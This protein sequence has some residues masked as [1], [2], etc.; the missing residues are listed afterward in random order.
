[1]IAK[2]KKLN[3]K[4]I[5]EDKLVTSYYQAVQFYEKNQT[6]ILIGAA[7]VVAI[8]LAV[9]WYSN[10][11]MQ[12]N[13]MAN[14]QLS[15]VLPAYNAGNYQLAIDGQDGTPNSGLKKIVEEYGSTDQGE[16]AKLYLANSYYFLG[17]YEEALNYYDSFS[18][19]S[20]DFKAAAAA[21]IAACELANGNKEDA[22]DDYIGA[23]N[24][25]S[26][27]PNNAEYLLNAGK[28]YLELGDTK[29]AKKIFDEI[30]DKYSTTSAGKLVSR[31]STGL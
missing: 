8:V 13:M 29:E 6:P 26:D 31:Y 21:G 9:V 20:A 4:E 18:G 11:T 19:G 5:Q 10:K 7:I 3:K 17:N 24:V 27:N 14:T 23:A 16:I 15:R 12:E 2:K 28:I 25:S 1:M 22:A 30:N